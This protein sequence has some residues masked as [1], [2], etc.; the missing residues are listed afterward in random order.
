MIFPEIDFVE[1]WNKKHIEMIRLIKPIDLV[2]I[3]QKRRIS[4]EMPAHLSEKKY[5]PD[6]WDWHDLKKKI[7][8]QY[9]TFTVEGE[10]MGFV[11]CR[12]V[13]NLKF[14]KFVLRDEKN[15]R[16]VSIYILESGSVDFT[17]CKTS[18]AS[19]TDVQYIRNNLNGSTKI[20]AYKRM[21]EEGKVFSMSQITNQSI[22]HKTVVKKKTGPKM[23]SKPQDLS[24]FQAKRFKTSVYEP[25]VTHNNLRGIR[26]MD[27]SKDALSIYM[28]LCP[29]EAE[30][31]L[32]REEAVKYSRLPETSK[33]EYL[34]TLFANHPDGKVLKS[35]AELDS[36]YTDTDAL[37]S[38]F[39]VELPLFVTSSSGKNVKILMGWSIHSNK[40]L[41]NHEAFAKFL[42]SKMGDF[43]RISSL[44]VDGEKSFSIYSQILQCPL[45]RC[46][47]HI[48]SNIKDK[49]GK[50]GKELVDILMGSMS[51][52][53]N[54]IMGLLHCGTLDEMTEKIESLYLD[55]GLNDDWYSYLKKNGK[56]L[57]DGCS[58]Y[59]KIYCGMVTLYNST[60]RTEQMNCDFKRA[61]AK[62]VS[63]ADIAQF[64][65]DYSN[66]TVLD[67]YRSL[68]FDDGPIRFL[69]FSESS[70]LDSVQLTAYAGRL[71]FHES[72][73]LF[74]N[75]PI[76]FYSSLDLSILVK[77]YDITK[78]LKVNVIQIGLYHIEN[79]ELSSSARFVTVFTEDSL[80]CQKCTDFEP[81]S[82]CEHLLA[83]LNSLSETDRFVNLCKLEL[84]KRK[85]ITER[86]ELLKSAP[87]G[88][89]QKCPRKASE[90]SHH[91]DQRIINRVVL[92]PALCH[93]QIIRETNEENPTAESSS[94]SDNS[95]MFN[96][97]ESSFEDVT[98]TETTVHD[99]NIEIGSI[100]SED[101]VFPA[102]N[103]NPDLNKTTS[104]IPEKHNT[105]CSKK[106]V[107]RDFLSSAFLS[108][109]QFIADHNKVALSD[110]YC[111]NLAKMVNCIMDGISECSKC[112]V[113]S[114]REHGN[115]F[116]NACDQFATMHWKPFLFPSGSDF[117]A[118]LKTLKFG[119]TDFGD[120]SLDDSIES[121][122]QLGTDKER[123]PIVNVLQ[124]SNSV[125]QE[126]CSTKMKEVPQKP[127]RPKR[128]N[129]KRTSYDKNG[130][131]EIVND[132]KVYRYA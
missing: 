111:A 116:C 100:T 28:A 57:F 22:T 132:K 37:V 119:T 6:D 51:P 25:Y 56:M 86:K 36:T 112:G 53:G 129:G 8:P 49:F 44:T 61:I 113:C 70:K 84:K 10:K 94:S 54:W 32:Q 99:E 92:N 45:L 126:G 31:H 106:E 35:G 128:N 124:P 50:N 77:N 101:D 64:L 46:Q 11:K 27:F 90:R 78:R 30:I 105:N 97:Y 41:V 107:M 15:T 1:E 72:E 33:I 82:L 19:P 91:N 110:D 26:F 115:L 87:V 95:V 68:K 85:E 93:N 43:K 102:E 3:I 21:A 7:F 88:A 122:N 69:K 62:Q 60:N 24:A 23:V 14:F 29:S 73:V 130:P 67:L 121:L 80:I 120:S 42:A 89:G 52:S 47:V 71:G 17:S 34:N 131:F 103:P 108:D 20:G 16:V 98:T 2:E 83:V 79:P 125:V 118:S 96:N 65:L 104:E 76:S 48:A 9:G 74:W 58:V 123:N 55:G 59:S 38:T 39:A 18:R 40:E 12:Q 4:F 109:I 75:W 13:E 117:C 114:E 66:K 127:E 5:P 81:H 63:Q